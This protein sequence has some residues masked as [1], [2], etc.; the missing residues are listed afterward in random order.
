L[1]IDH[2]RI[3]ASISLPEGVVFK[4]WCQEE[5]SSTM[6]SARGVLSEVA[7]DNFGLVMTQKQS[8]GRGRRGR[9][10]ISSELAFLGTYI[11]PLPQDDI[12]GLRA[13]SLVVGCALKGCLERFGCRA[14]LKWPNDLLS[15]KGAKLGGILTEIAQSTNLCHVLVGIGVNL[16]GAPQSVENATC[17]AASYGRYISLEEFAIELSYELWKSWARFRSGGFE[18]FRADWLSASLFTGKTVA[19]MEESESVVGVMVDVSHEGAL[20][21]KTEKGLREVFSGDLV[22]IQGIKCFNV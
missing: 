3:A 13:F 1:A 5:T 20:V 22:R 19:L 21:L 14:Y 11:L 4:L 6:D 15:P 9:S 7:P 16:S 18:E 8:K 12:S 10:W 17:I 2:T